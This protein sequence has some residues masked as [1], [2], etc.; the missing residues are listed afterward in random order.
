MASRAPSRLEQT[1]SAS[2]QASAAA[3]EATGGTAHTVEQPGSAVNVSQQA[4]KVAPAPAVMGFPASR[5]L[6]VLCSSPLRRLDAESG[7]EARAGSASPPEKP[8]TV[9]P[10]QENSDSDED[11]NFPLLRAAET[12][13]RVGHGRRRGLRGLLSFLKRTP[14]KET[15]DSASFF[16]TQAPKAYAEQ[17]KSSKPQAAAEAAAPEAAAAATAA[18]AAAEAS[19]SSAQPSSGLVSTF[20][21]TGSGSRDHTDS[22]AN[23]T[24]GQLGVTAVTRGNPRKQMKPSDWFSRKVSDVSKTHSDTEDSTTSRSTISSAVREYDIPPATSPEN[25]S[26]QSGRSSALGYGPSFAAAASSQPS[27][28]QRTSSDTT[29]S[30]KAPRKYKY[31]NP[32]R[33]R[34]DGMGRSLDDGSTVAP[35]GSRIY[36]ISSEAGIKAG[37]VTPSQPTYGTSQSMVLSSPSTHRTSETA[38]PKAHAYRPGTGAVGDVRPP[39][40]PSKRPRV[41][42]ALTVHSG[43]GVPYPGAS[44]PPAFGTSAVADRGQIVHGE[45]YLRTPRPSLPWFSVRRSASAPAVITAAGAEPSEPSA[46]AAGQTASPGAAAKADESAP[47]QPSK[48]PRR[49]A[50]LF[51]RSSASS[52]TAATVA[53]TPKPSP[54]RSTMAATTSIWGRNI[55]GRSKPT[56]WKHGGPVDYGLFH[57]PPYY[58]KTRETAKQFWNMFAFCNSPNGFLALMRR[59]SR[60]HDL[61][62]CD[63]LFQLSTTFG[64]CLENWTD[65]ELCRDFR[66]FWDLVKYDMTMT[67]KVLTHESSS[68]RAT[69]IQKHS[70]G[71]VRFLREN[72]PSLDFHYHL[73][74]VR[75]ELRVGYGGTMQL[76]KVSHASVKY[77]E[78]SQPWARPAIKCLT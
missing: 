67:G 38:S 62:L 44:Q 5:P 78:D 1:S 17:T 64:C 36:S 2:G 42:S 4:G 14:K 53:R 10:D 16:A 7:L 6:E 65:F 20:T 3:A 51:S 24:S 23:V 45:R 18:P 8:S 46:A 70:T 58:Y 26:K 32:R 52:S 9:T 21:T 61:R 77:N 63:E 48:W 29:S 69:E 35:A 50:R 12:D 28:R 60:Q 72:K 22:S 68:E 47:S 74:F 11:E 19:A 13:H 76:W 59:A 39:P 41:P 25:R 43:R 33:V 66:Q 49:L 34:L 31:H 30:G 75:T 15:S 54:A 73:W 27:Q 55:H 71:T 56:M 57:A 37:G 40:N